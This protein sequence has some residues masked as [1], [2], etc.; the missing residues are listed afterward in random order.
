MSC[1]IRI[2][3]MQDA[4]SIQGLSTQ[5]GYPLT[6]AAIEEKIRLY[7]VREQHRLFVAELDTVVIGLL[8]CVC[9]VGFDR[10]GQCMHIPSLVVDEQYRGRGI[11]QQLMSAAMDY[12]RDNHCKGVDLVSLERRRQ[13]GTHNFYEKLGFLDGSKTT[14]TFF[15]KDLD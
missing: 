2:A 3:T 8:A 1:Q 7:S 15:C 6:L 10:E 12:A 11:G 9:Y 13:D 14:L 5:L 4:F